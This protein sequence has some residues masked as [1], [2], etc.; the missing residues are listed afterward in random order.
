MMS[1]QVLNLWQ[2]R[3]S[4]ALRSIFEDER[5]R[6]SCRVTGLRNVFFSEFPLLM[7]PLRRGYQVLS[8]KLNVGRTS[9]F[10]DGLAF[11][12]SVAK[13]SRTVLL[14]VALR[15]EG[16][17]L[18]L[19]CS[20]GDSWEGAGVGLRILVKPRALRYVGRF[21]TELRGD[22]VDDAQSLD[23]VVID[24][25]GMM[26]G[27]CVARV[28]KLLAADERVNSVAVNLLTETAAISLQ[29]SEDNR[30]VGNELASRLTVS[31]FPSKPRLTENVEGSIGRKRKELASKRE[32]LM[33]RSRGNVTF[34]WAL[35]ALCCGTH[36]THFMHSLGV[37]DFMEGISTCLNCLD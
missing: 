24:V 3:G 35:T 36:A 29:S 14:R 33:R 31:G 17:G 6:K 30:R 19:P 12:R 9:S 10:V 27:A 34:A 21:E 22:I 15:R 11:H 2:P 37:H 20:F 1:L 18:G 28:R 25:Q 5:A 23:S 16:S 8:C 32:D 26:C 4:S 13:C 7:G